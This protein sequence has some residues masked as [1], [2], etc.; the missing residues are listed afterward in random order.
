MDDAS[1]NEGSISGGWCLD[2]VTSAP[3][4]NNMQFAATNF[5]GNANGTGTVTVNRV[6]LGAGAVS[7]NYATSNGT[8]T[9]GASCTTG[10][11]Y[12]PTSGTLNFADGE[13][14]KTFTV[15]LCPDISLEPNETINLTLSNP[16]GSAF[17]GT[18]GTATLT[19]IP[20]VRQLCSFAIRI[21]LTFR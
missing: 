19:I 3:A 10:V 5:N 4:A 14:S 11:D 1:S 16:T 12:I 17:I 18:P 8:A 20:P 13:T 15:Q 2:I 9:G 7:I 6:N 21:R